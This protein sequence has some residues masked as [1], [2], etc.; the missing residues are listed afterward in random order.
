[1][2]LIKINPVSN[3]TAVEPFKIA[4]KN[5]NE[6]KSILSDSIWKISGKSISKAT[7]MGIIIDKAIISG[8]KTESCLFILFIELKI[9]LTHRLSALVADKQKNLT[10]KFVPLHHH[11]FGIVLLL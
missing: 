6:L 1:M 3:N 10:L 5:G 8:T 11:S 7:T 4:W 9:Y 2:F